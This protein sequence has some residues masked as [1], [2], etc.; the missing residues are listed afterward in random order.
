MSVCII[1][2]PPWNTPFRSLI[3]DLMNKY[4]PTE[5]V[6]SENAWKTVLDE[7][8]AEFGFNPY[9]TVKQNMLV[10]RKLTIFTGAI[11]LPTPPFKLDLRDELCKAIGNYIHTY[12]V[13]PKYWETT[14]EN[15]DALNGMLWCLR[16]FE[17]IMH[18]SIFLPQLMGLPIKL[19]KEKKMDIESLAETWSD[20]VR[21]DLTQ[22]LRDLGGGP[23]SLLGP[24][25]TLWKECMA[26]D[27]KEGGVIMVD[28]EVEFNVRMNSE[29]A[30]SYTCVSA[31]GVWYAADDIDDYPNDIHPH[32]KPAW[33]LL[34]RGWECEYEGKRMRDPGF[35][36]TG[37]YTL[38]SPKGERRVFNPPINYKGW[39]KLA[40]KMVEKE[41]WKLHKV[42]QGS[43]PFLPAGAVSHE[44]MLIK[45]MKTV[46]GQE[47][48]DKLIKAR[49]TLKDAGELK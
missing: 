32:L 31:H 19:I 39:A 35:N 37:S 15:W 38:I 4:A 45:G 36:G 9:E 10:G 26:E 23:Q 13:N 43:L 34:Q 2:D 29:E 16:E 18:D 20:K 30:S 21:T 47:L 27:V 1:D 46:T 28:G 40:M 12:G 24:I 5:F 17:G 7:L 48:E 8:K 11:P 3:K 33:R 14:E 41:G 49:E 44:Y 25:D 42:D 6:I 22:Q